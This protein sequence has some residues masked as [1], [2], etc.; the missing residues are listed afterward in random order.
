MVGGDAPARLHRFDQLRR[1]AFLYQERH[2]I[3]PSQSI[4]GQRVEHAP[5][6]GSAAPGCPP[7]RRRNSFAAPPTGPGRRLVHRNGRSE[8]ASGAARRETAHGQHQAAA[9][10]KATGQPKG[11]RPA[12]KADAPI[13]NIAPG[14]QRRGRRHHRRGSLG[15]QQVGLAVRRPRQ[16]PGWS[17]TTQASTA[18]TPIQPQGLAAIRSWATQA[19]AMPDPFTIRVSCKST[20]NRPRR[21]SG[22]CKASESSNGAQ[23]HFL[24]V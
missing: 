6:R 14:S 3:S 4:Q 10:R 7:V 19:E 21:R 24:S 17:L 2:T 16:C 12:L 23:Q 22:H 20:S 5:V 1:K 11:D 15:G 8:Q 13:A 18:I 9:A